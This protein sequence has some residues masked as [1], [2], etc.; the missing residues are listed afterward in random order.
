MS[1][2]DDERDRLDQLHADRGDERVDRAEL[3]AEV[4]YLR[5]TGDLL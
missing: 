5:E 3:L 4:A 1:D 2:C